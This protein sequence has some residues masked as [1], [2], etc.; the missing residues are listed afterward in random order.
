MLECEKKKNEELKMMREKAKRPEYWWENG[1]DGLNFGQL[2]GFQSKLDSLKETVT[3]EASKFFQATVPPQNFYV[4]SSSNAGFGIDGG[5]SNAN[6]DLDLFGQRR[7]VN[8]NAFTNQNMMLPNHA[9]QF[10]NNGNVTE[11]FVP[12]YNVNNHQNLNQSQNLSFKTENISEF[13]H[14]SGHPPHPGSGHY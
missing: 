7:M 3:F 14:H 5:G 13:E 1:I 12:D 9:L 6:P 4:E 2:N 10:G 8:L 11:R